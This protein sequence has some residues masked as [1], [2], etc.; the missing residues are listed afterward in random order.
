MLWYWKSLLSTI[1][2]EC[3]LESPGSLVR[4]NQLLCIFLLLILRRVTRR[5]SLKICIMIIARWLSWIF[6]R[7][8]ITC[9][10][11]AISDVD[12]G[13]VVIALAYVVAV[14]GI[15]VATAAADAVGAAVAVIAVA[16]AGV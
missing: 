9:D 2:E 15:V 10:L 1:A 16:G 4:L 8:V 13:G 14:V 3:S 7:F 12:D 11:R 5:N 6:K